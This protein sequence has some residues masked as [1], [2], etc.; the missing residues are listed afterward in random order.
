MEVPRLDDEETLSDLVL[1]QGKRVLESLT[2]KA[3]RG[4][5]SMA[6]RRAKDEAQDSPSPKRAEQLRRSQRR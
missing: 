6:T 1:L 5:Q 2:K 3:K 4:G